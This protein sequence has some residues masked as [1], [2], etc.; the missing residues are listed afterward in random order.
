MVFVCQLEE[1]TERDYGGVLLLSVDREDMVAYVE[2]RGQFPSATPKPPFKFQLVHCSAPIS[3]R[4]SARRVYEW[5]EFH[6]RSGVDHLVVYDAGGIDE[7]VMRMLEVYGELGVVEVVNARQATAYEAWDHG[8]LLLIND[9]VQRH[10]FSARW[11]FFSDLEEYFVSEAGLTLLATL[12]AHDGKPYVSFGSRWWSV[13]KCV[14]PGGRAAAAAAT[15]ATA[16]GGTAAVRGQ[17]GAASGSSDSGGSKAMGDGVVLPAGAD[18]D[19]AGGVE[20]GAAGGSA[21]A[22]GAAASAAGRAGVWAVER[23]QFRWPHIYCTNKEEFP[24]VEL[25]LDFHGFRRVAVDPR[26]TMAVQIHRSEAPREG[27]IDLDTD[28]A[29]FNRYDGLMAASAGGRGREGER[30]VCAREMKKDEA[31]DWWVKDNAVALVAMEAR[32]TPRVRYKPAW[33][34]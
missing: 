25:C 3:G 11:V 12:N 10:R 19:S 7:P 28:V 6:L 27:G 17:A 26:Q 24:R 15:G 29:R 9:C 2:D 14:A 5:L 13:E 23:M 30:R 34:Q 33:G 21:V 31:V 20:G 22:E 8:R 18:A 32:Q 16:A 4:V 1:S